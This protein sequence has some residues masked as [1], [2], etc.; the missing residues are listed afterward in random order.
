[1]IKLI[2][3]APLRMGCSSYAGYRTLHHH[4][5]KVVFQTSCERIADTDNERR[6][7]Q[8]GKGRSIRQR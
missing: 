3:E 6:L 5:R 8:A 7:A 1:M 2:G 4:W